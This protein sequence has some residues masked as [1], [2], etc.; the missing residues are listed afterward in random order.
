M[1]F[2]LK[3]G[4]NQWIP[5]VDDRGN[6]PKQI[7]G[8]KDRGLR[9][10]ACA[11]KTEILIGRPSSVIDPCRDSITF[12]VRP[13]FIGRHPQSLPSCYIIDLIVGSEKRKATLTMLV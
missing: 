8:R 3:I 1:V 6:L 4:F 12:W 10:D 13:S 2:N 11:E 9:L 7:W 5:N